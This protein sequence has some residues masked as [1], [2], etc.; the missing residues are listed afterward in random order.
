MSMGMGMI[1]WGE[2][3]CIYEAFTMPTSSFT[4]A[5]SRPALA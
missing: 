4:Q 5:P 3:I 1:I 2:H